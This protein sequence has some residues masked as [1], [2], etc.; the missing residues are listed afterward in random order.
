MLDAFSWN[1]HAALLAVFH[2]CFY[3][4]NYLDLAV[5]LSYTD[6]SGEEM[7]LLMNVSL[8]CRALAPL[9][10]TDGFFYK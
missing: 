7:L 10:A 2:L 6:F 1:I 5:P 9:K 8:E 4:C 3:V